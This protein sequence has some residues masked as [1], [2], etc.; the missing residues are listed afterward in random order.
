MICLLGIC[1]C[2]VAIY[3]AAGIWFDDLERTLPQGI[4]IQDFDVDFSTFSQAQWH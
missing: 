2:V 4:G 3:S 1:G